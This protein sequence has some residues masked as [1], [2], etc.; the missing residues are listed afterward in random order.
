MLLLVFAPSSHQIVHIQQSIA[1]W[2]FLRSFIIPF[3]YF[4][5]QIENLNLIWIFFSNILF[6]AFVFNIQHPSAIDNAMEKYL[7]MLC[8]FQ[9]FM[10]KKRNGI[11]QLGFY[12]VMLLVERAFI[13]L[14]YN[15]LQAVEKLTIEIW[16]MMK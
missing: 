14:N 1:Q 2:N 4:L 6:V 3:Y 7:L 13:Q 9:Q 10:K 8:T 11:A 15:Y 16:K 12:I 5:F